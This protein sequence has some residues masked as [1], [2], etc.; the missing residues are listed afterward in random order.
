ME[1]VKF[2]REIIHF[3]LWITSILSHF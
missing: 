3:A 1:K 2:S